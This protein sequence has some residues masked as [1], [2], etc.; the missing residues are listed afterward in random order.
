MC[1]MLPDCFA[2]SNR[3]SREA[4]YRAILPENTRPQR[5]EGRAM[6]N[7]QYRHA[8]DRGNRERSARKAR[9]YRTRRISRGPGGIC[10]QK[11][12]Q[13]ATASTPGPP[14]SVTAWQVAA[15]RA[16]LTIE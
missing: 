14:D 7:L 1:G 10:E 16:A 3:G 4:S 11:G 9:G 2:T 8:K 13:A 5:M 12:H 6:G 15:V